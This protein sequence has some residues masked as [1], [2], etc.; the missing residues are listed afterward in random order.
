MRASERGY[1]HSA[2]RPPHAVIFRYDLLF[3]ILRNLR[4][5]SSPCRFIDWKY[6]YG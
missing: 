1:M 6:V 5:Y 4:Y 3:L 2:L